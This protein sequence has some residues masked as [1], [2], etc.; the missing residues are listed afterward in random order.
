MVQF[1][2]LNSDSLGKLLWK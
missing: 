2:G 1:C